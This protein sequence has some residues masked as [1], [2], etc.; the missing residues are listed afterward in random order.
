MAGSL[1]MSRLQGALYVFYVG[2]G[3]F[4]LPS[5]AYIPV[6][7]RTQNGSERIVPCDAYRPVETRAQAVLFSSERL[8]TRE[9]Y[10]ITVTKT[11]DTDSNSI[12][13]DAFILT[14][15]EGESV[16]IGPPGTTFSV[17]PPASG[18]DPPS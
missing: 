10:T 6:T 11:N 9:T 16:S 2:F 18:P 7:L 8:D 3:I 1:L 17:F 4:D 5:P 15:P 14:Q 12:N 13:I